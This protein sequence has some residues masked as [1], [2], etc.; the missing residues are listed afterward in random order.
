[1]VLVRKMIGTPAYSCPTPAPPCLHCAPHRP[2]CLHPITT[3]SNNPPPS[4]TPLQK[5][6]LRDRKILN[7]QLGAIAPPAPPAAAPAGKKRGGR[8]SPEDKSGGKSA[9]TQALRDN[10]Y[11]R[12]FFQVG[13]EEEEA[14]S[15]R[16]GQ[17]EG[18]E[19]AASVAAEL[20]SQV[21]VALD[22]D[23]P[24]PGQLA[25]PLWALAEQL[26]LEMDDLMPPLLPDTGLGDL[27]PCAAA[28]VRRADLLRRVL[29]VGAAPRVTTFSRDEP[30]PAA[31]PHRVAAVEIV[32]Q[33]LRTEVPAVVAELRTASPKQGAE[34]A[35]GALA[36]ALWLALDHPRC[37]AAQ[38]A[39]LRCARSCLSDA[40]GAVG[41]WRQALAPRSSGERLPD[42]LAEACGA[43][44][45]VPPGARCPSAGFALALAALLRD[46]CPRDDEDGGWRAELAGLLAEREAWVKLCGP[47]GPLQA[48][49]LE[50]Q[51]ELGGPK[52]ERLTLRADEDA[53]A[54]ILSGRDLISMLRGYNLMQQ[55]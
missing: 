47:E 31:G 38:G 19:D 35:Q 13:G 28:A 48:L 12:Q 22:R 42:A 15:P 11:V 6:T 29:L 2:H 24:R 27:K 26:Q 16:Q 55:A 49:L 36:S 20:W 39:A 1:M 5:K 40:A 3:T 34:P 7:V 25:A 54:S 10:S 30:V 50:Q 37:S 14:E 52:P 17:G 53:G 43:A 32:A 21:A 46:S 4:Q 45:G 18:F 51:G 23:R 41:L 8:A 33:L 44:L 9:L